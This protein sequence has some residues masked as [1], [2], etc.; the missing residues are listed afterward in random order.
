MKKVSVFLYVLCTAFLLIRCSSDPVEK[1]LLN[2][3]NVELVKV[4][5]L[6]SEAVAAY[7]SVAGNNYTSDS[8]M[9]NKIKNVVLPKYTEFTSKLQAITPAT[10]E[11]KTIHGE[12]VKAAQDQLEGFKLILDAIEKQNAAEI[13]QANEDITKGKNLIDVWKKDLDETCKKHNV[14]LGNGKK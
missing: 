4:G 2:Y 12:Y 9:Y 13:Q 14:T 6:E 8:V 3:I 1:D 10:P 11:L 5:T 7:G